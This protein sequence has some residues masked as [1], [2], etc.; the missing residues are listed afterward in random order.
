MSKFVTINDETQ[1]FI[2]IDTID[3]CMAVDP[4]KVSSGYRAVIITIDAKIPTP[5]TPGQLHDRIN[6]ELRCADCPS[7]AEPCFTTQ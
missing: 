3:C 2:S 7:H 1:E 4:D 5:L 6:N